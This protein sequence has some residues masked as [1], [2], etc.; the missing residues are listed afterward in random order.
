MGWRQVAS[1]SGM[2]DF[3]RGTDLSSS[4][5]DCCQGWGR[6]WQASH[7]KSKTLKTRE[8]AGSQGAAGSASPTAHEGP[9]VHATP[10]GGSLSDARAGST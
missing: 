7:Q 8:E 6:G 3:Q 1:G 5:S 4:V 9:G 2:L 10:T